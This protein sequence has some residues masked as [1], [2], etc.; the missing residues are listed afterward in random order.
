MNSNVVT[1]IDILKLSEAANGA[2]TVSKRVFFSFWVGAYNKEI[3]PLISKGKKSVDDVKT[4][5]DTAAC[6]SQTDI[7]QTL[8]EEIQKE[9][10]STKKGESPAIVMPSDMNKYFA[11][12]LKVALNAAVDCFEYEDEAVAAGAE[13]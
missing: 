3:E 5:C 11:S 8:K 4:F 10:D 12:E 2:Q 1:G 13:A 7:I 6:M 9:I